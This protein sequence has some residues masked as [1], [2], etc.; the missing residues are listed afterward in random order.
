MIMVN[1]HSEP[2]KGTTDKSYNLTRE[3][4]VISTCAVGVGLAAKHQAS[5][6][7][8]FPLHNWDFWQGKA[9]YV[10]G[11]VDKLSQ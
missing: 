11:D 4:E 6:T 8:E 9:W 3:D 7:Q 10:A 1:F 2:N 5:A